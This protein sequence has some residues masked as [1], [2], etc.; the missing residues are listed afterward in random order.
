MVIQKRIQGPS[1]WLSRK[2]PN[3]T[4]RMSIILWNSE[5]FPV[6]NQVASCYITWRQRYLWNIFN[7]ETLN[8]SS[9]NLQ[10]RITHSSSSW[11]INGLFHQRDGLIILTKRILPSSPTWPEIS[12][13]R[14][15]IH[16]ICT[17]GTLFGKNPPSMPSR[18]NTHLQKGNGLDR[19]HFRPSR[20]EFRDISA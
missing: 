10:W 2:R 13:L 17:G 11:C 8:K 16:Q 18:S 1:M 7:S 14:C 6:R 19:T 15:T 4:A 3:T 5:L 12:N 9:K 20:T